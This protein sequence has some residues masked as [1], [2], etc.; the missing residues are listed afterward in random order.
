MMRLILAPVLMT[1]AVASATAQTV[2]H[3]GHNMAGQTDAEMAYVTAMDQMHADM[4]I[5]FT[6]DV[7]VDFMRGMI[8]HHEGAVAMARVVLEHGTDPAV[9][10]LASAVIAA[11]EQ[12][13]AFMRA[14]LAER[15]Y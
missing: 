11:Q 14:W 5:E 2:D 7:D 8:P 4:A 6:G 12:E 10:D 3:G 15:G 13:I 1:F 9:R